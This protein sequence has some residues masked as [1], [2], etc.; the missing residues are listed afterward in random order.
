MNQKDKEILG[1]LVIVLVIVM[2]AQRRW[3]PST[4][5]FGTAHWMSEAM[6]QAAGL[7]G[8]VGLVLG[9]TLSG[10]LIR[11]KNYCHVLLVGATGSGK[12]L[13]IIPILLSYF[14]GS[15]VCVDVKG[16]LFKTCGRR[17]K[18]ERR[19]VIRLA[20]FNKG[21]DRLNPLDMIPSD[22]PIL[23]DT[24][25]AVA[26]SLVVRSG[27]E[28]DAHWNEKGVQIITALLVLVLMRFDG[29]ERSLNSIQE[30]ASDQ[31]LLFAAATV[32]QEMT[33][34][35]A[36]LGAQIKSLYDHDELL[37]KE[38]SS[39]LSTVARHL[40]F[41]DSEMVAQ[42]V[43]SST[44]DPHVLLKPGTTLFLQIPPDQLE[45]QKGLFRCWISTLVR[46][47]A[48]A[49]DER[50][51]ETLLI[52][53]EA[54]ALGSLTALEEA[55]VRGRS[56]GVR[57]LLA[58]QSDSQIQTAFKGKPTLIYDNCTCQIYLGAS[59][60]ETAERLSKSLGEWTQ[61][62]E[63]YNEN[64]SRSWNEGGYTPGQGQQVTR[65]SSFNYSVSGR[66]LMRPDEILR[67]KDNL[68]ICLI[69]GLAPILAKRIKWY[70][71]EDFKALVS[72][73]GQT[74]LIWLLF[75]AMAAAVAWVL[76]VGK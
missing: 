55:L 4:T 62:V 8:N 74:A 65:A 3:R 44:F 6:M 53:D 69:R 25:R 66:S 63:G 52:I 70:K 42:S 58:Y 21:S 24:A 36:R 45:A 12:S 41:L 18:I 27:S 34:M 54:S 1:I 71:D 15:V 32:L 17:R 16:D 2:F 29:E 28:P 59:S 51:A 50:K 20:P 47:I 5:A 11:I 56:A 13:L 22:S 57:L 76:T 49:G 60:I 68:L 38:G 23:I 19:R 72:H 48:A 30:I 40:A 75:A 37:T 31:K 26:D 14:R 67:L 9:R 10:K 7:L 43:S 64:R 33:G 39:V 46:V 73:S 35:P 61:C